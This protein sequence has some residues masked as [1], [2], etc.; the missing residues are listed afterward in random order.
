MLHYSLQDLRAGP[1]GETGLGYP[2]V[3]NGQM[4]NRKVRPE[5]VS[6]A[7]VGELA[8]TVANFL[9]N[10]VLDADEIVGGSFLTGDNLFS[11]EKLTASAFSDLVKHSWLQVYEHV[12][13]DVFAGACL[14]ERRV[15]CITTPI[16]SA[17]WLLT[18][19]PTAVHRV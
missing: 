16:T 10:D 19:R 8:D 7:I 18:I 6:R 4:L 2:A 11:V 9:T 5:P 17:T 13:R 3:I 15:E 1:C 14:G 12:M